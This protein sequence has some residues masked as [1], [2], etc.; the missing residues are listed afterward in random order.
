MAG[1]NGMRH[2]RHNPNNNNNNNNNP[3]DAG[4][5]NNQQPDR[6]VPSGSGED[7]GRRHR[8]RRGHGSHGRDRGSGHGN[9]N[10]NQQSDGAGRAGSG[11]GRDRHDRGGGRHRQPGLP[12]IDEDRLLR[13]VIDRLPSMASTGD[14]PIISIGGTIYNTASAGDSVP[15]SSK[16]AL[17]LEHATSSQSGGSLTGRKQKRLPSAGT[18]PDSEGAAGSRRAASFSRGTREP[19]RGYAETVKSDDGEELPKLSIAEGRRCVLI[20]RLRKNG[21]VKCANC[22][23]TGHAVDQCVH[24]REDGYVHGCP[25]CNTNHKFDDCLTVGRNREFF[26]L[27]ELR[28][29]RPPIWSTKEATRLWQ[30][31]DRPDMVLPWSPE[32][33]QGTRN[34][35]TIN[36]VNYHPETFPYAVDRLQD[37]QHLPR[38][39]KP[40]PPRLSIGSKRA[41]GGSPMDIETE[42]HH[43]P[44]PASHNGDAP[45][46]NAGQQVHGEVFRDSIIQTVSAPNITPAAHQS[47]PGQG[48]QLRESVLQNLPQPPPAP[49][50]AASLRS[51]GLRGPLPN[52]PQTPPVS[53]LN[54]DSGE[55]DE[56][57]MDMNDGTQSATVDPPV[58]AHVTRCMEGVPQGHCPN[59]FEG[60]CYCE[61]NDSNELCRACGAATFGDHW[62]LACKHARDM[63]NCCAIPRHPRTEC[64]IACRACWQE[65]D[66][67]DQEALLRIPMALECTKHCALCAVEKE[68]AEHAN[69]NCAGMVCPECP[70]TTDPKDRIHFSQDCPNVVCVAERCDVNAEARCTQHYPDCGSP[71]LD[72]ELINQLHVCQWSKV[73]VPFKIAERMVG[74]KKISV[75]VPRYQLVCNQNPEHQRAFA[76]DLEEIWANNNPIHYHPTSA[77]SAS[78]PNIRAAITC[79]R[80]RLSPSHRVNRPRGRTSHSGL[81]WRIGAT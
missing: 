17:A 21:K 56:Y 74:Y 31:Q 60:V 35:W 63:C 44:A 62:V 11:V 48:Q 20:E 12:T 78:K 32:F 70:D 72:H 26:Y 51:L 81:R 69:R 36:G 39:P 30:D 27:V 80:F 13:Y 77:S 64:G 29:N 5:N 45:A 50:R 3:P 7:R 46:A 28:S 58:P 73:L 65:T 40:K 43:C 66:P 25:V 24:A 16:A 38:D 67:N 53:Y 1:N 6:P 54:Q 41:R 9:R 34:G 18:A 61:Q 52:L 22:D 33:A 49:R 37:L 75:V 14:R 2:S 10:N 4:N 47:G 55:G 71:A 15:P 79:I 19:L 59:C 76:R 68:T 8:R 57:D 23:R 42:K